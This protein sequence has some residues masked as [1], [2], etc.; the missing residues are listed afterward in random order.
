M[1]GL[2]LTTEA[3]DR[4]GD[5][6]SLLT[7]L[8]QVDLARFFIVGSYARYGESARN[9][10]KDA[11]VLIT[12]AC[13]SFSRKRENYLIWAAPGT[14]KT[15]FVQQTAA[16]L[17][18]YTD[19]TELNL[20]KCGEEEFRMGLEQLTHAKRPVLCLIDEVDAKPQEPWP[21]ELLLPYLDAPVEQGKHLVFVLAGSSGTTRSDLKERIATRPK[22]TDLLSR[23]PE[24]NE[25]DIPPM[26]IGDRLLVVLSQFNQAAGELGR[27]VEAVEKL[28]L[29]YIA[30]TPYL[31]N[32]RQLRE[33]AY[34]AVERMASGDDRI[35]Y[36]N[37]FDPGDTTNKRFWADA[38]EVR[39][40]LENSYLTLV[41]AASRRQSG[42]PEPARRL[43]HNLPIQPTRLIGRDREVTAVCQ[44]LLQEDV[45]LLTLTGPGGAGK[46]RLGLQV[47]DDLLEH[48][49]DGVF[50]IAL[51]AVREQNQVASALS[52]TLGL[53]HEQ[54]DTRPLLER[55][56]DHL[57]EKALLVVLD[58]FEQVVAAA[59]LIADLLASCPRLK[60]LVTSRVALHLRAE[61]EFPVPP[62]ALPDVKRLPAVEALSQYAAV[63]LFI[64]RAS[65]VRP[66]FVI[67]NETA[68][69]VAEICTRLDG[70]PL[71]IELAAAHSKVLPPRALLARLEQRLPLLAG[72]A[73]DLPVRQQTMR[74]AIAWSY[75]L[76]EE[77]DRQVFR[78]LAVFVSGMTLE[79]A[80]GVCTEASGG[81]LDVL[82]RLASLVD[83]NLLRQQES[84]DGEPRFIMLEMVREYGQEQLVEHGEL[85]VLGRHH[86]AYYVELAYQAAQPLEGTEQA[87]LLVR[88]EREHDNLRAALR[89]SRVFGAGE[90]ALRGKA[91]AYAELAAR[92]ARAVY[93]YGEAVSLLEEALQLQEVLAPNDQAK[94][95]DV[96]LALGEALLSA[97]EPRRA[98]VEAALTAFS[99]AETLGD[100]P[101]AFQACQIALW[102]L[103]RTGAAAVLGSK[104]FRTWAELADTYAAPDSVERVQA[105]IA[106]SG[107]YIA[108][109]RQE[110][111]STLMRSALERA[112]KLDDSELLFWSAAVL[113]DLERS[114]NSQAYK[115]K[116]A[117]DL[118]DKHRDGVTVGTLGVFLMHCGGTFLS[119]A[120][121]ERA[122]ALWQ[123]LEELATRT[124]DPYVLL[125]P[126]RNR[127]LL[128]TLD[129][130]FE[131]ALKVANALA[132]RAEELA[133]PSFGNF[134]M[135]QVAFRPLLHIGNAEHALALIDKSATG[136]DWQAFSAPAQALCHA[137][138]GRTDD[139]AAALRRS[140]AA[141][142]GD[143]PEELSLN[144]MT[145]ALEAA[146]LLGDQDTALQFSERLTPCSTLLT[147]PDLTCVARHLASAA[148]LC[149]DPEG[150]WAYATSAFDIASKSRFRP[151][152][153]LSQLA[154][155]E[156]VIDH[157]PER[158][159]EASWYLDRAVAELRDMRM[160]VALQS[161]LRRRRLLDP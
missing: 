39:A 76:L 153:A 129:G 54:D 117:E 103:R 63:A 30:V 87:A 24:V 77:E 113:M 10:L 79:A 29:L 125:R 11:L 66:D 26:S 52:E 155:A 78:W 106:L 108:E 128:F 60:A 23:I 96:I 56:K 107:V 4:L 41:S 13:R 134:F 88:L 45:R 14:G 72:G 61:H 5:A 95:C 111:G 36:D 81:A 35:K 64:E 37:L 92:L 8:D 97:G 21:Y 1:R 127:A 101:R 112:R 75:E 149:G 40:D 105:D 120:H 51:A 25:I 71:A 142:R 160:E 19:Y 44:Q 90:P 130:Q 69:V 121:R 22:G 124:R 93:Q 148:A 7:S 12:A 98:V 157:F 151:E 82:E 2:P 122:E 156:I 70:L 68:P 136:P 144:G 57:R 16:Q 84:A 59:P 100:R 83:K 33:F 3:L 99:L 46:T 143:T 86:A 119:S 123:E 140:V 43:R 132:A 32:A 150:A 91:L 104:E 48:F 65:A 27:R 114:P 20:A 50:Y 145:E 158:Q 118:A 42:P 28:G 126:L 67:T 141:L 89:W 138:L 110:V 6:H 139:A 9:A 135:T 17:I 133:V 159:N 47:A 73:R 131:E 94:R 146:V 115:L 49:A 15:Y 137:S 74:N 161:A 85:D 31:G 152:I 53:T 34:R 102:G 58:N 62:L 109:G 154:L 55:L 116:I 80:E 147:L 38:K 18:P